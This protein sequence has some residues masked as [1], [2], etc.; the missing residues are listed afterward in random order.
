[1]KKLLLLLLCVPLIGLGQ[2]VNNDTI[3]K[4]LNVEIYRL[5][6]QLEDSYNQDAY[7][8]YCDHL[9]LDSLIEIIDK[10]ESELYSC[11]EMLQSYTNN[12]CCQAGYEPVDSISYW[13]NGNKKQLKISINEGSSYKFYREWYKNGKIKR[14]YVYGDCEVYHK[15]SGIICFD[16]NTREIEC[17]DD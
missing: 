13:N 1:M 14:I 11:D 3:I 12:W 7:M 15:L 9:D 6:I 5:Q 10:L 17:Q 2:S 16:R 4:N 8:S